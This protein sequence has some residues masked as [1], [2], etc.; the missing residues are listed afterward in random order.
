MILPDSEINK[1]ISNSELLINENGSAIS[2]QIAQNIS[3]DLSTKKFYSKEQ[4]SKE[5]TDTF[6]LRPL[7]SVFVASLERINLPNDVV[8][9]VKLKYSLMTD[10]LMLDAP[11]Y[12]PGH[13]G[14]NIFFRLTNILNKDIELE[15]EKKYAY[16]VFHQVAGNVDKPYDGKFCNPQTSINEIREHSYSGV[17]LDIMNDIDRT[18][19]KLNNT[20][21]TIYGNVLVIITVFITLFSLLSSFFSTKSDNFSEQRS[22]TFLI[23]GS[24]FALVG[25]V[26]VVI[27]DDKHPILKPVILW[28]VAIA[29]FILSFVF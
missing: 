1:R 9:E 29:F 28:G 11:L 18:R 17:Y 8:A 4:D 3:Y 7:D 14:S 15:R 20:E 16:I 19:A 5:G 23:L 13:N 25:A 2:F 22:T 27:G 24:I 6:E 26:C 10:G 12:Q 21:K